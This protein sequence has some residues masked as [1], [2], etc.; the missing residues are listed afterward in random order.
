MSR[1]HEIEDKA[2]EQAID[3]VGLWL[4]KR[5]Q[6][7]GCG[8]FSSSHEIRGVLDDEFEELKEA[9]HDKDMNQI[10]WELRD[11]AVGCIFSMACIQ[12][13]TLDW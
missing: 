12:Q 10:Y 7:K 13:G 8:S 5:I 4:G 6:E 3:Q 1:R 2:L 11:I 9:L